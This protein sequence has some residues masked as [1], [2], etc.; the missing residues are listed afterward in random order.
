MNNELKARLVAALESSIANA[1]DLLDYWLMNM[2]DQ[3][4]KNKT[5][6]DAYRDEIAECQ[7]LINEIN[8]K[9]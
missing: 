5:V 4:A 9:S 7:A 8:Q 3:S 2:G 6:A 1:G